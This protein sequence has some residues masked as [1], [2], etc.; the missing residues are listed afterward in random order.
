MRIKKIGVIY[1]KELLDLMRDKRTIVS[2]LVLPIILYPLIMIG[3]SSMMMRQEQKIQQKQMRIF[4]IDEARTPDT[5][6]LRDSLEAVP[7]FDVHPKDACAPLPYHNGQ[8]DTSLRLQLD[9]DTF[10]AI[11][12]IP[13]SAADSAG[14]RRYPLYNVEVL[15]NSA[16][17]RSSAAGEKAGD[18]L[19]NAEKTLVSRRFPPDE[20]KAGLLEA[21]DLHLNSVA[22]QKAMIGFLIGRL[23]PYFLIILTISN[24]AVI[25]SDLVAGEK[26]R[27]TMETLLVS[28]ADRNEIVVGKFLT[29]I[30]FSLVSV[31]MNIASMFVSIRHLASQ[32]SAQGN[33]PF[34]FDQIP[35][36][37]FALVLLTMVPLVMFFAGLLLS[38]SA[39]SRNMR[40]ANTYLTPLMIVAMLMSLLTMLPGMDMTLGL[41]FIP[42]LNIALLFK[43]IM[44]DP[45]AM[46]PLWVLITIGSTL[47]LDVLVVWLTV[48][49][50]N[51]EST[52]F[53]V[54]EEKSLKFWGKHKRNVFSPQLAGLVFIGVLVLFYYV[55]GAWQ[56]ADQARGLMMT[57]LILILLPPLLLLRLAKVDWRREFR[58]TRPPVRALVF[59]VLMA[60][61]AY[62]LAAGVMQLIDLIYPIPAEYLKVLQEAVSLENLSLGMVL[63]VMGVL[64]GLCEE[65]LM[66]GYIY[67]SFRSYGPWTAIVVSAVLFGIMHLDP[68]RLLPAA[69]IGLYLGILLWRSGSIW[70]P[71]VAHA[72]N[73][74]LAVLLSRV[75]IDKPLGN[76]LLNGDNFAWWVTPASAVLF[77]ALLW[78]FLRSFPAPADQPEAPLEA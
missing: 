19:T 60:A 10:Q 47:V 23:L 48:K 76:V 45:G 17:E 77:A 37:S 35:L 64:P 62:V 73:N 40:E 11:V 50:F 32:V 12:V 2:S 18:V 26:E 46:N 8:I 39:Y 61:P 72:V 59:A 75:V 27:G 78:G 1:R 71:I 4:L 5:A 74:S 21:V 38:I 33:M 66:R 65:T 70:V 63:L 52:L 30:T 34:S 53:R 31:L 7:N 15:Y 20:L 14:A 36:L 9:D 44:L 42:I 29:V 24:G 56:A 69:L 41:A 51:S 16:D 57:E 68:F 43:E 67:R 13:A 22:S 6:L 54:E 49:L 58:F 28:A 3:F 55:G 25:S